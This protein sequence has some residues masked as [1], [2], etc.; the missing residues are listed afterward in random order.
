[1]LETRDRLVP[2]IAAIEPLEVF[3]EP[4]GAGF[5]FGSRSVAVDMVAVN[6]EMA[7]RGWGFGPLS[8]PPGLIVLLNAG[9]AAIVAELLDDLADA[10]AGAR[11]GRIVAEAGPTDYTV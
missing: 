4:E 2:A 5:A 8:E 6:Q 10:V 3:G 7:R 9:H 11:S 1:M